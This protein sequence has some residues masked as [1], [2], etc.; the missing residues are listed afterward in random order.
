MICRS[1]PLLLVLAALLLLASASAFKAHDFKKCAD[2]RFCRVQRDREGLDA[3]AQYAVEGRPALSGDGLLATALLRHGAAG[4]AAR[5]KLEVTAVG[6]GVFRVI[7]DEVSRPKARRRV[8]DALVSPL[9]HAAMALNGDGAST[10]VTCAGNRL[11]ITH[12]PFRVDAYSGAVLVMSLNSRGLF[13]IEPAGAASPESFNSHTD[14]QDEGPQSVGFDLGFVG[15]KRVFGIPEHATSFALPPTKGKTEPY[16]MYNLDVFEYDLDLPFGLYGSVP[17]MWSHG[18][19][20]EGAEARGT[21][22]GAVFLNSAEMYIDVEEYRDSP[23]VLGTISGLFGGAKPNRTVDT[24]WMAESGVMDL[25][26]LL[27]PT[28]ADISK[29]YATLSGTATLP[30]LFSLGYH[31]C[32]WN[33]RDEADVAAVDAGFDKHDIPYDVLWLDIEHTDG[34]KYFTWDSSLFPTPAEMQRKVARKGRKMVTITD[35]HIKR[36]SGYWV[37]D[38]ATTQGLFV[39]NSDGSSDF[40]GHCWPGASSYLDM[41]NPAARKFWGDVFGR[42]EGST[43]YLHDWIDMNEPSVFSGPEITMPKNLK[44]NGDVEHRHVHNMFG[45]YQHMATYDG[46]VRAHPNRRPFILS[47]SFFIGTQRY[48]AIWTGDNMAKWSHLKISVPMLLSCNV[49][50]ITFSGADVGG[51]FYNPESELLVRWYQAAALTPFF[52][53]HAHL[54]TKRREPW[55]FGDDNTALIRDAIRLRYSLLPFIYTVFAQSADTGLPVMRPL[56]YE[57]PHD[58]GLVTLDDQFMLGREIMVAPIVEEGQTARQVV[59]PGAEPFYD[60]VTGQCWGGGQ[61]IT[62]KAPLSKIPAYQRGGTI[63]ARRFRPRRSSVATVLDPI[64]LVVALDRAGS[65]K[66]DVYLDDGASFNFKKGARCH[67]AFSYADGKLTSTVL[68]QHTNPTPECEVRIERIIV[69]YP[70]GLPGNAPAA[71]RP[72]VVSAGESALSFEWEPTSSRLV[73][74]APGNKT[75]LVASKKWVVSV[76]K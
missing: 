6:G 32:R 10:T 27:G 29:Q 47:R 61:T 48:G 50:G 57:W 73:I 65:A 20:G 64:T 31:Q 12:S 19:D 70:H 23:G 17:F 15:A 53:G 56:W 34:K 39:K 54:E 44:H 16:R 59:M 71:V 22:A 51:F 60:V 13:H 52:R 4:A 55:L 40:D 5:V 76:A 28:P 21:S 35:P 49:A 67:T 7:A 75:P 14:P 3:A 33:Y 62:I 72:S 41:T 18:V 38:E 37:Y 11:V 2:Q 58:A 30:P 66:G 9:P 25:L 45:F 42:Y 74:R 69:M 26:L 46:M 1:R 68:K 63:V 36:E 24:Q 8:P 43:E